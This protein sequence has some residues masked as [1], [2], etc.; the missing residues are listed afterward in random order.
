MPRVIVTGEVKNSADWEKGF[1]THGK[2]F[3]EYSATTINFAATGDN[4]FAILWELDD[5]AKFFSLMESEATIEAMEFDGVKRETVKVY[6]LDKV[7]DL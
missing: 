7:F 1:R 4:E 2:L 3:K 6:E 5:V